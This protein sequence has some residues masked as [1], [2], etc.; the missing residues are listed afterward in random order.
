M[1]HHC[2]AKHSRVCKQSRKAFWVISFIILVWKQHGYVMIN[3][4]IWSLPFKWNLCFLYV[5]LVS[6]SPKKGNILQLLQEYVNLWEQLY[7]PWRVLI[8][9]VK[10]FY[11]KDPIFINFLWISCQFLLWHCCWAVGGKKNK[12]IG[13]VEEKER[14]HTKE[15]DMWGLQQWASLLI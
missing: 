7:K 5:F 1:L 13:K 3:S 15:G 14:G 4:F 10:G 6:F 12:R 2:H 11:I 9:K 8:W